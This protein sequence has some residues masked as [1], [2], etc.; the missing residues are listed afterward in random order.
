M[1]K[2]PL[3]VGYK[4]EIGSFILQGL[5]KKLPKANNIW[6]IDIN[7]SQKEITER[8]KK[9]DVIFL[10]IPI[11]KTEKWLMKY[12]R[13]LKNKMIVEQTSLK[14]NIFT[15]S[16]KWFGFKIIHMHLLFK[17]SGTPNPID[18]RCVLIN[19]GLI[20]QEL[21]L[22]IK[23]ITYSDMILMSSIAQHDKEMAIQQALLHRT[24]LNLDKFL[25]RSNA[26]TF[27]AGKIKELT[28]RIKTVNPE[29]FKIIQ[30]NIFLPS[31]LEH[32][33]KE[34]DYGNTL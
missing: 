16:T 10:C 20:P 22:F 21:I 18:R 14:T 6:C 7:N 30:S 1:F 17:P 33:K 13:Y 11:E 3:V 34:L 27:I 26:N 24:L 15:P 25:S 32:F 9:S 19:N 2:N 23:E 31:V 4:G 29:L 12:K 5:L 8:I 28:A